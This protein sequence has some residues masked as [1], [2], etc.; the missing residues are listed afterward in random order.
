MT[1]KAKGNVEAPCSNYGMF[2]F[3]LYLKTKDLKTKISKFTRRRY[4]TLPLSDKGKR[5]ITRLSEARIE[6]DEIPVPGNETIE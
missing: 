4:R 2:P 5:G 1:D 6:P 3:R